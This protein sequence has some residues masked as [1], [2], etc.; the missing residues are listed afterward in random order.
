MSKPGQSQLVFST[1][2]CTY[3]RGRQRQLT[4]K[5]PRRCGMALTRSGSGLVMLPFYY[6]RCCLCSFIYCECTL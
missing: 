3:C 1:H 6:V 5:S 4:R 2:D